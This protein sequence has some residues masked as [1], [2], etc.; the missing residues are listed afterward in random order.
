MKRLSTAIYLPQQG[1]VFR[2]L[3]D[4]TCLTPPDPADIKPPG[5]ATFPI[6][7][8]NYGA[9]PTF[10]ATDVEVDE[11]AWDYRFSSLGPGAQDPYFTDMWSLLSASH[12]SLISITGC[13]CIGEGIDRPGLTI[14]R[15]AFPRVTPLSFFRVQDI[16]ID[17]DVNVRP[18]N[19]DD[20]IPGY[21][22]TSDDQEGE[23][24]KLSYEDGELVAYRQ[25]KEDKEYRYYHDTANTDFRITK[26]F[27]RYCCVT[28]PCTGKTTYQLIHFPRWMAFRDPYGAGE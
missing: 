14:N 4:G 7:S 12:Q 18:N 1:G 17:T 24:L 22:C 25:Q 13:Y 6:K 23:K 15:P 10:F 11:Y 26:G 27:P 5:C 9:L 3:P 8:N 2:T 19:T 16:D 21:C 28:D 20:K